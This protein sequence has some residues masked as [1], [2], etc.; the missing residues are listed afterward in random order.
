MYGYNYRQCAFKN[1]CD[2]FN[3]EYYLLPFMYVF[4]VRITSDLCGPFIYIFFFAVHTDLIKIA[5]VFK[6]PRFNGDFRNKNHDFKS[7]T[8]K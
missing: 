7:C 1:G 3:A 2:I 4:K 6:P 5:V 8:H